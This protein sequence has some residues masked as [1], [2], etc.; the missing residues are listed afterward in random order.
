MMRPLLF[1]SLCIGGS[2]LFCTVE[3]MLLDGWS[4][5]QRLRHEKYLKLPQDFSDCLSF[6]T[7][8]DFR[9]RQVLSPIRVI[10]SH[11]CDV[12]LEEKP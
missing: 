5:F 8:H 10:I 7:M 2:L 3:W 9:S 4:D 12:V 11:P 6:A 1:W